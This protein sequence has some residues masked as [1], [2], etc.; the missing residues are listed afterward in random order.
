MIYGRQLTFW[1]L[2]FLV[3]AAVLWLL[4]DILL[5]FV[6]G[7]ALAY[8]LAPL[9]DRVERL[10]VNRTVAALIVVS[11][12]VVALIALMLLLVPLL[13]QQGASLI[14]H[15]PGYFKRIKELIVDPNFPWLNWLGSAET[16]KTAS[17]L[18]GQV[19]PEFL[20]FIVDR[21]KGAGLIRVGAD[22]DA[23]RDLLLDPRLACDDRPGGQLDTGAPT[24]DR[25]S[26]RPRD[27]RGDRWF[28]ARTVRRLPRAR[29][30]L[31]D[32][33]DVG[34]AGFRAAHRSHRRRDHVRS[35]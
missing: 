35:L 10:G 8:V 15:I 26:A 31:R 5:P 3:L 27:R 6:A 32:W 13:L 18:V 24:R 33:T 28:S 14:S 9:A 22:R 2:T 23:G 4:H 25:A 16:G 11:V 1:L 7:I 29:L 19:A 34:G 12:L 20:V 17:D 30:L 21:R